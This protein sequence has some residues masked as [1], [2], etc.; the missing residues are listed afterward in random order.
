MVMANWTLDEIVDIDL[1]TG[2][3]TRSKPDERPKTD[4]D[5]AIETGRWHSLSAREQRTLLGVE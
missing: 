3:V 4:L 1:D 2:V 5:V